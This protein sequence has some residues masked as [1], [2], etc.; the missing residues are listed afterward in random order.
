M[1]SPTTIATKIVWRWHRLR[2]YTVIGSKPRCF[3]LRL[4]TKSVWIWHTARHWETS[5]GGHKLHIFTANIRTFHSRYGRYVIITN[6]FHELC[7]STISGT[8]D[9]G[10]AP[11]GPK[12]MHILIMS[13]I[14]HCHRKYDMRKWGV[15]GRPHHLGQPAMCWR[16]SKN[17]FVYAS[18]RG[19]TQGIQ[20][21]KAMQGG[22]SD[23]RPSCMAGRPNKWASC[24]QSL[25]RAPP[26]SSYKYHDAAPPLAESVKKVRF[27]SPQGASKF[28]LCRVEREARFWGP[29]D[30]PAC[31][32]SL[33]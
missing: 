19:G 30:F 14:R 7:W 32:E 20:C 31:Q 1:S 25:A 9:D 27:S 4:R 2:C 8:S 13:K 22:N 16:I 21:P 11:Y 17:C 28:N 33:E 5:V 24:A 26:Y 10:K 23:T 18:S 15:V 29:E 6:E 3:G 12:S